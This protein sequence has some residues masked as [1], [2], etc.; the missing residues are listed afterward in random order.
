MKNT[1][2]KY[3]IKSVSMT[4]DS[5]IENN[6]KRNISINKKINKISVKIKINYGNKR[7]KEIICANNKI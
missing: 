2:N 1:I 3:S 4:K 7:I 5:K 6:Q